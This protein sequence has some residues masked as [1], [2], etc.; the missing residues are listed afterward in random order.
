M[1]RRIIPS[2]GDLD[3]SDIVLPCKVEGNHAQM[4]SCLLAQLAL[5]TTGLPELGAD[6]GP[7]LQTSAV[8]DA[9][10]PKK[11][12]TPVFI[13]YTCSSIPT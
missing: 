2:Q 3:I 1:Q 9:L 13:P 11:V 12:G 8:L 7:A 6:S 4:A 10:G 5:N